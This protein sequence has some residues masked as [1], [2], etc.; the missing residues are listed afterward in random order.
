M[1][2]SGFFGHERIPVFS[3]RHLERRDALD[4]FHETIG[5]ADNLR[6]VPS[7]DQG[8]NRASESDVEEPHPARQLIYPATS[9]GRSALSSI[10][11]TASTIH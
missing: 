3:V 7:P 8:E 5:S 10:T 9:S 11:I 6:P 1:M 2:F 4:K